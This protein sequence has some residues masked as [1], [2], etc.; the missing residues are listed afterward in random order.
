MTRE[1]L[2]DDVLDELGGALAGR[3]MMMLHLIDSRNGWIGD[4]GMQNDH[5]RLAEYGFDLSACP[6]PLAESEV[7]VHLFA[8]DVPQKRSW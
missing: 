3:L 7:S 6:C 2:S 4:S 8:S 5:V 1:G